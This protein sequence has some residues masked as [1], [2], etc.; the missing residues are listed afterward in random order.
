PR[1]RRRHA[2]EP[3]HP[4]HAL[5]RGELVPRLL[6]LGRV[7]DPPAHRD[8]LERAR[9]EHGQRAA[10]RPEQAG[11]HLHQRRLAGAVGAEQADD[12]AAQAPAHVGD[13]EHV[14]VP[15]A[16]AVGDHDAHDDPPS[17]GRC[18]RRT[19]Y[20]MIEIAADAWITSDASAIDGSTRFERPEV[21]TMP[22]RSN[23]SASSAVA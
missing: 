19:L 12:A 15:L 10:R 23:V 21:W 2:G 1:P 13:P 8:V 7:P 5:E 20:A 4:R 6:V 18:A 9:A 11:H 16:A 14:A 22:N 3:G 17:P